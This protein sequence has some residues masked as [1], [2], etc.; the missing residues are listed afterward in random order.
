[1][2][3]SQYQSKI[4]QLESNGFCNFP[5]QVNT[6]AVLLDIFSKVSSLEDFIHFRRNFS[7]E[8]IY[9]PAIKM[10][11]F[12][13]WIRIFWYIYDYHVLYDATFI[14]RLDESNLWTKEHFLN[15]LKQLYKLII[16]EWGIDYSP[17]F[18][19]AVTFCKEDI[20]SIIKKYCTEKKILSYNAEFHIHPIERKWSINKILFFRSLPTN[21]LI[22]KMFVDYDEGANTKRLATDF[23]S[24]YFI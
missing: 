6:F 10:N 19:L 9:I 15:H 4:D 14:A 24:Y 17:D 2:L 13:L 12:S 21:S 22:E 3:S 5:K 7:P 18:D 8:W 23:L 11:N 20:I 16:C 1:M